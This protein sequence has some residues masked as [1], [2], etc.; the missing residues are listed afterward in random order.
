MQHLQE[1]CSR[2]TQSNAE[3][4]RNWNERWGWSSLHHPSSIPMATL[5][6][7]HPRKSDDFSTSS[8]MKWWGWLSIDHR[9]EWGLHA[10][11]HEKNMFH[12]V[13]LP[14]CDAQSFIPT[15]ETVNFVFQRW[16]ILFNVRWE[17]RSVW[18]FS[19]QLDWKV[20]ERSNRDFPSNHW[21]VWVTT[22]SL[23]YRFDRH[24]HWTDIKNKWT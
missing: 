1:C 24:E 4:N 19:P 20:A 14:I 16:K 18:V 3:R 10:T 5:P 21:F 13:S 17:H 23:P 15:A 6:H 11:K 9:H 22:L 12:R 2:A 7:P 8:A